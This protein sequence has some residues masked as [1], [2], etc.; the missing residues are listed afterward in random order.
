MSP[1]PIKP[2]LI[3][4]LPYW[5]SRIFSAIDAEAMEVAGQVVN[6]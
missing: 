2:F 6:G 1:H 3:P 4:F 5:L